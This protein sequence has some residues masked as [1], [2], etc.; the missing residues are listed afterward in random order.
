L[1]IAIK[2]ARAANDK[3]KFKM[4]DGKCSFFGREHSASGTTDR[5]SVLPSGR[6]G[7]NTNIA[8]FLV[9]RKNTQK[10]TEFS[11][12]TQNDGA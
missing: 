9:N 2:A 11:I 6:Q 8:A 12:D 7:A 4:T 3:W 1:V 5:M 10:F